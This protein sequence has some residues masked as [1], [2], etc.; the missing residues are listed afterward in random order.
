MRHIPERKKSARVAEI[1]RGIAGRGSPAT[2]RQPRIAAG[3]FAGLG[4]RGIAGLIPSDPLTYSSQ[5]RSA[6]W[7]SGRRRWSQSRIAQ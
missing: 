5:C 2:D 4:A 7:M 1:M 6:G 3:G